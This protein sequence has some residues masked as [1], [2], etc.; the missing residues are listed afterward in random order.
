VPLKGIVWNEVYTY[1]KR[2]GEKSKKPAFQDIFY[3]LG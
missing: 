1:K 2:A 3:D